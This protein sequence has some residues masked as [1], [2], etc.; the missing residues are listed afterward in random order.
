MVEMSWKALNDWQL[1]V[2]HKRSGLPI[3]RHHIKNKNAFQERILGLAKNLEPGEQGL[4][5]ELIGPGLFRGC[6]QGGICRP[7]QGHSILPKSS[8]LQEN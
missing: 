6:K 7:G 4:Q 2:Q 3:G 8:P 1:I 5:I